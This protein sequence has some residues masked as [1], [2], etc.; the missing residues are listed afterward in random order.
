MVVGVS[1]IGGGRQVQGIP[2][3][4]DGLD[5]GVFFGDLFTLKVLLRRKT[6]K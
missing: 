4:C 3:T 6:K 1:E 5:K 2:H